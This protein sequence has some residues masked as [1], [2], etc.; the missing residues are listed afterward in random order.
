MT[1][2]SA[3]QKRSHPRSGPSSEPER[4][5]SVDSGLLKEGSLVV[6]GVTYEGDH[7]IVKKQANSVKVSNFH[8]ISDPFSPFGT[9]AGSRMNQDCSRK[10][11][12][13]DGDKGMSD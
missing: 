6:R 2:P 7:C 9:G 8:F 1:I 4:D 11:L 5:R 10:V 13:K 12:L 3:R